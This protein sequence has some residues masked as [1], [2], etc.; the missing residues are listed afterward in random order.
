MNIE[1]T[2]KLRLTA[3][4]AEYIKDLIVR[5]EHI[6]RAQIKT[7]LKDKYKN[8]GEDCISELY[9]LAC[10]KIDILKNHKSPKGWIIVASKNV[11]LNMARKQNTILKNSTKEEIKDHKTEDDIFEEALY[12]I[13]I[14]NGSIEKL[15]NTLTPYEREIYDMIYKQGIPQKHVAKIKGVSDS[16]IRNIVANIK[17]KIKT[18]IET[19]LF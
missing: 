10:K 5:N 6:I 4:E 13:W 2:P 9:L 7:V 1:K 8:I 18:A 19:K 11:A 12:N 17:K 15:L 3:E 14:E 16:T